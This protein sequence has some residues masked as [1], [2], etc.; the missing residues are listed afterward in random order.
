M[1]NQHI[2]LALQSEEC[3]ITSVLTLDSREGNSFLRGKKWMKSEEDWKNSNG[4]DLIR[5]FSLTDV[6]SKCKFEFWTA[7]QTKQSPRFHFNMKVISVFTI[8]SIILMCY[9]WADSKLCRLNWICS[10]EH[11]HFYFSQFIYT[12]D[13]LN[14]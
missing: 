7:G 5:H 6:R 13:N 12:K 11:H 10:R 14:V 8:F 1:Y 4:T 9:I 2:K 3:F